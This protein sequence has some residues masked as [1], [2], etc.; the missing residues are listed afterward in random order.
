MKKENLDMS[1]LKRNW[2]GLAIIAILLCCV[3]VLGRAQTSIPWQ[4][5]V[6]GLHATCTVSPVTVP[7]ST[8]YCFAS[9]GLWQSVNGAAYTQVGITAVTGVTSFNGRTG[10][11]VPVSSDYPDAVT[12]VNGK[13]GAVVLSATTTVN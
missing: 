2:I 3:G 5:T 13:T 12:S 4:A 6:T 8:T 9:D 11:V 1:W 10:A 7:A